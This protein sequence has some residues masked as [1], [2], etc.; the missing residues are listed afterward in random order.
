LCAWGRCPRGHGLFSNRTTKSRLCA[1]VPLFVEGA[2]IPVVYTDP[3]TQNVF[4]NLPPYLRQKKIL[5]NKI[6]VHL[7]AEE[8]R[9]LLVTR[10]ASTSPSPASSDGDSGHDGHPRSGLHGESYGGGP[11]LLGFP[12]YRGVVDGEIP[13]WRLQTWQRRPWRPTDRRWRRG[14]GHA[15]PPRDVCWKSKSIKE[16]QKRCSC[17]RA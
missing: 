7:R 15:T 11:V 9:G 10:L 8:R 6:I 16:K 12:C 17:G 1:A 2:K 3:V 13:R 14:C 4:G 5:F